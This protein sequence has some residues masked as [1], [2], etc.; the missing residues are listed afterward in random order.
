V[1]AVFNFS[2]VVVLSIVQE[3]QKML[4]RKKKKRDRI[5]LNSEALLYCER[6]EQS[7]LRFH[8]LRVSADGRS[9]YSRWGRVD[10]PLYRANQKKR[11]A[12]KEDALN[13]FNLERNEKL[14]V[15]EGWIEKE[16]MRLILL[17]PL[18][19]FFSVTFV[20]LSHVSVASF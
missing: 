2:R 16:G 18:L 11:Y 14:S 20:L 7:V 13:H 3:R 17:L 15:V 9:L 5:P 19:C 10:R 8:E 4:S 12:T 1:G 6:E